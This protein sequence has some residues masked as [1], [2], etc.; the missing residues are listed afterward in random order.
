MISH[1]K[2]WYHSERTCAKE[3]HVHPCL[4]CP[5]SSRGDIRDALVNFTVSGGEVEETVEGRREFTELQMNN[6]P[7]DL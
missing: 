5:C 1:L 6:P 3:T 2:H 4:L 7:P